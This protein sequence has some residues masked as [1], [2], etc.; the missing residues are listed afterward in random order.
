MNLYKTY[1]DKLYEKIVLDVNIGDVLLMGKFKNKKVIVKNIGKDEHGM[2][3]INGKKVVTFRL[4]PKTEIKTPKHQYPTS[5]ADSSLTILKKIIKN[6]KYWDKEKLTKNILNNFF[7]F[8]KKENKDLKGD[9][10]SLNDKEKANLAD[11]IRIQSKKLGKTEETTTSDIA[12]YSSKNA[13]RKKE[14][15]DDL[16]QYLLDDEEDK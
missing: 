1:L 15:E 14:K 2:P 10:A 7:K 9:L 5:R 6:K 3:T 4:M 12:G 16:E 13:F 11:Y 8:V